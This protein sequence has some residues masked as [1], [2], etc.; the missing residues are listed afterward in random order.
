MSDNVKVLVVGAGYMAKEYCKVLQAQNVEPVVVGR[1][2][3]SAKIFEEEM[4]IPV[5]AG[6][7][8][9]AL[10]EIESIPEMAIVAVNVDQLADSTEAL[11]N[12][13]VKRILV[14]KPAGIDKAEIESVLHLMKEKKAEIYVAYNRRYYA[15]TEKALE[16]IEQDGG[17]TSFH[18]E[19]TEWSHVIEKTGHA[20]IVKENWFLAN[21]SHVVD[22]AFFLG[23][24]PREISAYVKGEL[25]WYK[26][27]S[28]FAG[29]GISEKGAVFS[30]QANWAAPGRWGVEVLTA[31]H[32]LYFRPMEQ[33]A[34]QELGTV[35]VENVDI[36][37]VL[38]KK[39][40]PGLYKQTEAFVKDSDDGKRISLEE[41][42]RHMSFY[43]EMENCE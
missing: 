35:K 21:S 14:E 40:K 27:A 12:A 43:K 42:L 34:I 6:G 9:N 8:V 41:Q 11:L 20:P 39:F 24:F 26:K 37:D 4:G 7:I 18:F 36:N 1:G 31:K 15:S 33:L 16:I 38:E 3:E 19:F 10:Q 23:G 2:V 32:R 25:S 17:V 22:L 29:A 13:G 28:A 30:Y 5:I